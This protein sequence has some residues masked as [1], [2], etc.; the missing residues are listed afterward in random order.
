MHINEDKLPIKY[1]LG[2]EK[3][4]PEY[5]CGLDILYYEIRLCERQP[6][7]YKGTFTFH[8]LKTYHFPDCNKTS[9]KNALQELI[10]DGLI[11][12]IKFEDDKE[13]YK[14]LKNPFE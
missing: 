8:M 14:I 5:P 1:I 6:N 9:L 7:K 2:V 4:M 13:S 11:E 3:D 12:Q 10:N